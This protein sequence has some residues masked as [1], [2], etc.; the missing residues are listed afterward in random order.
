MSKNRNKQLCFRRISRFKHKIRR[1]M[2]TKIIL[3]FAELFYARILA[4]KNTDGKNTMKN[5]S[6]PLHLSFVGFDRVVIGFVVRLGGCFRIAVAAAAALGIHRR[7]AE[8]VQG[9]FVEFSVFL[10]DSHARD[11]RLAKHIDAYDSSAAVGRGNLRVELGHKLQ[12]FG[13]VVVFVL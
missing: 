9:I 10:A 2:K 1:K 6:A 12:C 4:R 13:V 5:T 11:Y 8:F 7:Y 3:R